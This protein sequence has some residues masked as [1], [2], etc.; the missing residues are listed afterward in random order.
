[1]TRAV[2][3]CAG[4]AAVL[5]ALSGCAGGDEDRA[6]SSTRG[7]T[8]T[9]PVAAQSTGGAAPPTRTS[10][11][12]DS[13]APAPPGTSDETIESG[14]ET[15]S[16]QLD[17]PPSYDGRR[18][19]ALVLGLHSL[20]V[21]YKVV[22]GMTGFGEM[23]AAHDFVGVAPSGLVARAT[24]FWNAAPVDDNYDVAFLAD[25]LD[26]LEATLCLDTSRVFS[27]GMSNG[28]QMS[29]LI[30]CA[31]QGRVAAIAPI[32]GVEFP[33][34]CDGPPVPV[35][36]FH[37]TT[38]P[39]VPYGGGGLSATRIAELHH[40]TAG[41]PPGLPASLGVDDSMARWAAHNGCGSEFLEERVSPEVRRRTWPGCEAATEI[42]LV[43]GGGH[44]WPGKPVPQFEA[45]FGHA[46]TEIDA[47]ALLFDFFFG[48][49]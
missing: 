6:A 48:E 20:T 37:G 40:Y 46:T 41:L 27:V 33:Q 44:A 7:S 26:H 39:I 47:S 36:A 45:A 49:S 22:P 25:L 18:P 29:S 23:F 10:A 2:R 15:R 9:S 17:I 3:A 5:V 12:C 32:A 8:P 13:D 31:L 30:A 42:Y 14:G 28:A 1:V 35:I 11:G 4:A 19:Y 38:D 24:P 34:P 21:S 43:D 16:Y